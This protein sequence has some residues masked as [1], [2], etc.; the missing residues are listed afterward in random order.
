MEKAQLSYVK[1]RV[2]RKNI[3]SFLDAFCGDF[4][5]LTVPEIYTTHGSG[6]FV[7]K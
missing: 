3:Q 4:M 2:N 6:T 1:D 7:V 5:H